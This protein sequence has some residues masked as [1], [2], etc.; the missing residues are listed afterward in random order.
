MTVAMGS[1]EAVRVAAVREA[2]APFAWQSFTAESVGR[3]AVSALAGAG[4]FSGLPD[5][6]GV[7]DECADALGEF[8]GRWPWR[9]CAV[10]AVS[11]R[12]VGAAQAWHE[13]RVWF[14]VR[15]GL[16]LDGV[17]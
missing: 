6:G 2:L 14:D 16:M 7:R 13:E 11:R 10:D 9:S 3:R 1:A 12:L 4:A 5:S 17:G 15:L 8:L